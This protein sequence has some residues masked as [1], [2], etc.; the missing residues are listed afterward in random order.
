MTQWMRGRG[1]ASLLLLALA[2]CHPGPQPDEF[3]PL[4]RGHQ[5]TY[6]ITTRADNGDTA[7]ESLS[8]TSLDAA[9]MPDDGQGVP[10]R[11][12]SDDGVEY[13]LRADDKGVQRVA[14]RSLGDPQP[15]PDTPPAP[16]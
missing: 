2:A 3:F 7:Q 4:A 12:R 15:R 5:W 14:S 16:C 11:R 10:G 1:L 13:W 6:R 8:L 9:A